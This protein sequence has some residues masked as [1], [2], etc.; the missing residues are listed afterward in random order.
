MATY[1]GPY[2]KGVQVFPS[3]RRFQNKGVNEHW[4]HAVS[5]SP[6]SVPCVGRTPWRQEHLF[7]TGPKVPS[8]QGPLHSSL[9]AA[10]QREHFFFT[11]VANKPAA[12]PQIL[13]VSPTTTLYGG[14]SVRIPVLQI[15]KLSARKIKQYG[16]SYT[17]QSKDLIQRKFP[18]PAALNYNKRIFFFFIS[19]SRKRD[20]EREGLLQHSGV[21]RAL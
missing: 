14:H 16:E 20:E 13:S 10:F 11:K 21:R 7:L 6:H 3:T 12:A 18:F 9:C 15:R 1:T 17:W 4:H 2:R 19:R 8:V 5:C